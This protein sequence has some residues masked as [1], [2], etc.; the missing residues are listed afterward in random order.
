MSL[1]DWLAAS[2]HAALLEALRAVA[3]ADGDLD[4]TEQQ[5]VVALVARLGLQP[6]EGA[7]RVW[8]SQP[9]GA[10]A[11]GLVET[12]RFNC[13]F[14]LSQALE[15]ALA[16]GDYSASE[17]ERIE[18]WATA[19]SITKE[20]LATIEEEVRRALAPQDDPFL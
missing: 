12:D 9:V 19:W 5:M 11:K 6:S 7:L 20:E 10:D 17:R 15:L 3:W 1:P 4:E 14:I 2:P 8:L 13:V 18:G 16:D